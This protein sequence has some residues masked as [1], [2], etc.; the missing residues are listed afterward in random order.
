MAKLSLITSLFLAGHTL[1]QSNSTNETCPS[2][3]RDIRDGGFGSWFNSTGTISV[4]MDNQDDP[5]QISAS[6]TDTRAERVWY[7]EQRSMQWLSIWVSV[8][9]SLVG[10]EKGNKTNVCVYMMDGEKVNGTATNATEP[11]DSCDGIIGDECF[12][13]YETFDRPLLQTGECPPMRK[14]DNC[15]RFTTRQSEFSHDPYLR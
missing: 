8:P 12:E 1:A 4:Q 9:K 7:G 5:W 15:D 10:T 6:L 3:V 11:K 2:A 14:S 13:E